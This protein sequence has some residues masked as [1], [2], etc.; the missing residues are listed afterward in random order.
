MKLKPTQCVYYPRIKRMVNA[1]HFVQPGGRPYLSRAA[2]RRRCGWCECRAAAGTPSSCAGVRQ[3]VDNVCKQE[4]AGGLRISRPWKPHSQGATPLAHPLQLHPGV[5]RRGALNAHQRRLHTAR[6][7]AFNPERRTRGAAACLQQQAE[8]VAAAA[9]GREH[10]CAAHAAPGQALQ[11]VRQIDLAHARRQQHV[12]LA[13]ARRRLQALVRLRTRSARSPCPRQRST[14]IIC[15]G[16]RTHAHTFDSEHSACP[17]EDAQVIRCTTG[18]QLAR[19]QR[20][21]PGSGTRPAAR[22]PAARPGCASA[23]R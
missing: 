22:P 19:R 23:S 3:G 5:A 13:Q 7:R 18:R 17:T 2:S 1:E 16:G 8:Q 4:S 15:L 9:C 11:Q 10:D 14:P 12:L 21:T 6:C 20:I